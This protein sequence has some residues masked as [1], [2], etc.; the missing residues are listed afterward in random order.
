MR[1]SRR[2]QGKIKG[3]LAS[4]ILFFAIVSGVAL[5]AGRLTATPNL[6][7]APGGA[8]HGPTPSAIATYIAQQVNGQWLNSQNA[9]VVLSEKDLTVVAQASNPD[10]SR[11]ANPQVRV[12]SN[13]VIVDAVSNIGPLV[14]VSTSAIALSVDSQ[15]ASAP[16]LQTDVADFKIGLQ[17]IPGFIRSGYDPRGPA[18][19]S[20]ATVLNDTPDMASLRNDLECVAVKSDGVHLGF[21]RP[22]SPA[23]PNSC[24]S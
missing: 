19:L 1:S 22:N 11:F 3:C 7:A 16:T 9:V 2:E 14:V 23:S 12:R 20:L 8:S 13:Q 5:L 21:H 18:A 24:N 4:L 17:E 15:D 6:G 10:P